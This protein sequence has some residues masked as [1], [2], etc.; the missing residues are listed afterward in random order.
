MNTPGLI[1]RDFSDIKAIMS[2]MGQAMMGSGTARGENGALDAAR[3]AIHSPMLEEEE[4]RGARGILINIT[5]SSQISLHDVDAACTLIQETAHNDDVIVNFGIVLNEKM[6]DEVK[7]TI[8]ATGFGMEPEPPPQVIQPPAP[9]FFSSPTSSPSP[10][11][12]DPTPG[13][14][15]HP[16]PGLPEPLEPGADPELDPEP[17]LVNAAAAATNGHVHDEP[18]KVVDDLEVPAF[19]RRDRRNFMNS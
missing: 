11:S 16:A 5:A 8:I 17:V 3:L 6:G 9:S 12:A 1:N 2:G 10:A 4:M 19:L 18:V 13:S 7:V 15:S 14:E